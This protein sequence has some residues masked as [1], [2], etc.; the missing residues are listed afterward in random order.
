MAPLVGDVAPV[1]FVP[2]LPKVF[3]TWCSEPAHRFAR[4]PAV[5][6]QLPCDPATV[7]EYETPRWY[8]GKA[9]YLLLALLILAFALAG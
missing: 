9:L 6:T 2:D 4:R 7:A 8:D 1:T 3:I 5:V